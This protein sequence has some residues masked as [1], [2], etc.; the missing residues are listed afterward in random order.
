MNNGTKAKAKKIVVPGD[1]AQGGFKLVTDFFRFGI[2]NCF[3][4]YTCVR[5]K[6]KFTKT[7]PM[8]FYNKR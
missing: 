4:S 3:N 8:T 7:Q 1:C 5:T 6:R 2:K